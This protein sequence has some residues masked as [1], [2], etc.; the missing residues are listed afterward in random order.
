M[1]AIFL[2]VDGVVATPT[3]VRLNY[4]LGRG[5]ERQLYDGVAL[6]YLG[7]LVAETGA[8]VVLSSNWRADLGSPDP[9][10]ESIMANLLDQLAAAGAPVA[11]VTPVCYG[12]DRSVE[13]GA[14][15]DEHPC[16]AYV[17]LDDLACFEERP[18]VAEGHLVLV[19]ESD[20][21]RWQHYLRARALLCG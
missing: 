17:I 14:W 12:H 16:E 8:L 4:L 7:R 9:F 18:E 2:D 15:L 5:P 11:G 19:E 21:L 10:M 1:K 13:V 20:G 3:S 6:G